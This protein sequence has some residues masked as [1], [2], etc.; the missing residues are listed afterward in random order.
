MKTGTVPV[1]GKYKEPGKPQHFWHQSVVGNP[2]P[3]PKNMGRSLLPVT[4]NWPPKAKF[5]ASEARFMRSKAA[6]KAVRKRSKEGFG[7]FEAGLG[8]SENRSSNACPKA[9]RWPPGIVLRDQNR[10]AGTGMWRSRHLFSCGGH[11]SRGAWPRR[12]PLAVTPTRPET[13]FRSL[14]TESWPTLRRLPA[15]N[16]CSLKPLHRSLLHSDL[17]TEF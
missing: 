8:E 16:F 6:M 4:Q 3:R 12:H 14:E 10:G 2:L 17:G 9:C 15:P 13:G 1:P 5:K 11:Q 7:T